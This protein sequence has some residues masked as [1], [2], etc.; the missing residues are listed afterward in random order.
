MKDHEKIHSV[1]ACGQEFKLNGQNVSIHMKNHNDEKRIKCD[2]CEYSTPYP[3]YLREHMK[4]HYEKLFECNE[5]YYSID[6]T[7]TA[8]NLRNHIKAH[9]GEKSHKCKQC[10]YASVHASSLRKHL[11]IHIRRKTI[12]M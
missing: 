8:I 5:C 12:Q 3:R 6:A 7:T 2:Q 9:V 1:E 10:K 4:I 11:K